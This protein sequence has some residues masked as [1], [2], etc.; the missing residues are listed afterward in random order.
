MPSYLVTGANRG[1]GFEFV[2]QLGSRPDNTVF[3]LVRARS[4]S[5]DLLA[6]QEGK[7]NVHVIEGDITKP[8]TLAKAA[9]YVSKTT[10]GTLDVLINNASLVSDTVG[11][12]LDKYPSPEALETDFLV[13]FKTIV[14]GTIHATN[15]FL[16]LILSSASSSP[17]TFTPKVI[18]L[19]SGMG[20]IDFILNTG[21]ESHVPYSVGKAAQA[22]M[23]AKYAAEYEKENVLFLTISPGLV[24]TNTGPL[25]PEQLKVAEKLVAAFKRAA[26]EWNG[27][28]LTPEQSV[29]KMFAVIDGLTKKDSGA[30]LSQNGNKQWL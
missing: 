24:D 14:L 15:A 3:G 4:R 28:P 9:D 2:K 8:D 10:G 20:D 7:A 13:T 5:T 12:P 18:T 25:E 17:S 11:F 26:P 19:G 29:K 23:V 22:A 30:F 21:I 1:I 27:A 16:P 6:F